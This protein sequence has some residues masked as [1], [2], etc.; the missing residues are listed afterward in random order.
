MSSFSPLLI[1]SEHE[2]NT[3][4]EAVTSGREVFES[5]GE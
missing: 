1:A 5:L 2:W 4:A 3:D